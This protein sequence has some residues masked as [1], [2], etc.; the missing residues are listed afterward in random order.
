MTTIISQYKKIGSTICDGS[1]RVGRLTSQD[2]IDT[3][4]LQLVCVE[5]RGRY[6]VIKRCRSNDV[7]FPKIILVRIIQLPLAS[8][9]KKWT[10]LH[11]KQ[12]HQTANV[13]V[14]PYATVD[15]T[16]R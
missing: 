3:G 16:W 15:Q 11:A 9:H 5:M 6:R 10:I 14:S 12:P 7:K 1:S 13:P 2:G 8:I 4:I